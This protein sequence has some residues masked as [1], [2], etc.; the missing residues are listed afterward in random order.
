MAQSPARPPAR[1]EDQCSASHRMALCSNLRGR[2]SSSATD[3]KRPATG[4]TG[5]PG[6]QLLGGS[7]SAPILVAVAVHAALITGQHLLML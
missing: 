6:F 7:V 2:E 4:V 1:P 5:R 3:S